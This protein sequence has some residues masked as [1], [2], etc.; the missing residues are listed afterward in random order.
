MTHS[1]VTISGP[2]AGTDDTSMGRRFDQTT[3]QQDPGRGGNAHDRRRVMPARERAQWF[4]RF[5]AGVD[6]GALDRDRR[7]NHTSPYGAMMCDVCN[8]ED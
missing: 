5:V 1:I 7:H 2:I 4:R 3:A 6:Q 8:P